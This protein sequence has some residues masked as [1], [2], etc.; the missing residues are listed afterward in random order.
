VRRKLDKRRVLGEKTGTY[1]FQEPN[2]PDNEREI[3][4]AFTITEQGNNRV[5]VTLEGR[6]VAATGS[7]IREDIISKI[8]E[9]THV[10]FDLTKV[11]HIDSSGIGVFVQV[12]QKAKA[13]AGRVTLAGLQPGPRLV[14][15]ITKIDRVFEIVPTLAD[16]KYD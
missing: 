14:F 3:D 16:V 4:M 7:T 11:G 15:E 13:H 9:G 8:T 12:L 2:P 10:V 6:F 1:I 5:L